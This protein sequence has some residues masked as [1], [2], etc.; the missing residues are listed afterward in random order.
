M[1]S[2]EAQHLGPWGSSLR[3]LPAGATSHHVLFSFS[4]QGDMG[5]LGPIGYPGPKGMKV[6]EGS[7]SSAPEGRYL[8]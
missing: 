7:S 5:A 8:R 6:N 2:L 4:S 3:G 1:A